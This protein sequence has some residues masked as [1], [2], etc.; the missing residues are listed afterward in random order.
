MAKRSP[1]PQR[2]RMPR[3]QRQVLAG[4]AAVVVAVSVG[5][6]A[7]RAAAN[8]PGTPVPSQ[9]NL[10]IA[11]VTS[12]HAPYNSE[13]PTSGPHLPYIA[14]WGV[15]TRPIPREL[16]VHNLEDGGVLVQY[17]C[18]CPDVVARLRA[19]VGRYD[20]HVILAP[21]PGLAPRIALTAWT[22]I[23]T[24]DELDEG[25]VVRFIEAFRGIDHH[26]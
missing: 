24:L 22:R 3:R 25:R 4:A 18:E 9:G 8:L 15:H 12:P 6:F 16:Q 21:S 11:M 2:R 20:T 1:E 23:D 17:G 19:I 13:P 26:R 10:H 7:Y 14:P 5:W